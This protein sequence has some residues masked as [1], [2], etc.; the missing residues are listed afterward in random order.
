MKK[1]SVLILM[2]LVIAMAMCSCGGGSDSGSNSD[3]VYKTEAEWADDTGYCFAVAVDGYDGDIFESGKYSFK[4]SLSK[5]EISNLDSAKTPRVW[6]V[7]VSNDLVDKT[8]DLTE[9]ELKGSVGG[10]GGDDLTLE[11]KKVIMYMLIRQKCMEIL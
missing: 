8:E 11:L 10:L 7:Y 5:D 9:D 2:S 4:S 1:K 6:D 3:S